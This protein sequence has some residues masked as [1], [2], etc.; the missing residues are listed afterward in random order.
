MVMGGLTDTPA[1][2]ALRGRIE[3]ARDA[4]QIIRNPL[5]AART[6]AEFQGLMAECSAAAAGADSKQG[7]AVTAR[8][9]RPRVLL[10]LMMAV[11]YNLLGGVMIKFN[12]PGILFRVR[13][14]RD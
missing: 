3:E 9:L 7:R 6:E 2:L 12:L 1:S 14:L 4:L 11:S 5:Y 13:V 8:R 10:A